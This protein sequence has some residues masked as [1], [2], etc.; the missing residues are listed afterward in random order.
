M[1]PCDTLRRCSSSS[2]GRGFERI[3]I[4]VWSF[5]REAKACFARLGF[6][7]FNERMTYG[8]STAETEGP[9]P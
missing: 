1:S 7:V 8:E 4:D 6:H 2:S 9:E 3:E 5:N